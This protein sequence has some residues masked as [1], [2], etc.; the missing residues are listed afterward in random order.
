MVNEFPWWLVRL[1]WSPHDVQVAPNRLDEHIPDPPS[2]SERRLYKRERPTARQRVARS[3]AI[4]VHWIDITLAKASGLMVPH[5]R[6][7]RLKPNGA[8]AKRKQKELTMLMRVVTGTPCRAANVL[9]QT[10]WFK[11]PMSRTVGSLS[12]KDVFKEVAKHV[13]FEELCTSTRDIELCTSGVYQLNH[14]KEVIKE[15]AAITKRGVRGG[16]ER[17]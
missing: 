16:R 11:H 7:I 10:N 13:V 17:G 5:K 4:R 2:S 15:V 8:K 14:L 12:L 1:L 9:S 3:A 6:Y